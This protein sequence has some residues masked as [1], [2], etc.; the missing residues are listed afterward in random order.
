MQ[1]FRAMMLQNG[2]N[3]RPHRQQQHALQNRTALSHLAIS[4]QEHEA[5]TL[6][7][8]TLVHLLQVLT[9]VGQA[10]VATDDNRDCRITAD[11]RCQPAHVEHKQ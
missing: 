7:P 3:H 2:S 9:E 8:S 4:D 1:A 11:V 10:V 5:F 6:Q